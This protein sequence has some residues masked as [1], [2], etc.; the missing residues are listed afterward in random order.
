MRKT[1]RAV[2]QRHLANFDDFPTAWEGITGNFTAPF[3]QVWLNTSTSETGAIG[4]QPKAKESGFLQITLYFPLGQGT[5][6]MEDRATALQAYF[7]GAVWVE[8]GVQVMITAPP[9]IAGVQ[10]LDNLLALPITINY[11]A[12]QL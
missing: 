12:H 5:G 11:T 9:L 8:N 3:Q 2:L 1:V 6:E 7:Y 10:R 4:E